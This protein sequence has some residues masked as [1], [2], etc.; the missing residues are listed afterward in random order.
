LVAGSDSRRGE[1][2]GHLGVAALSSVLATHRAPGVEWRN[3]VRRDGDVAHARVGLRRADV[4]LPPIRTT[5]GRM[6]NVA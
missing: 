6:L 1:P 4:G 5:A 2:L 3:Q